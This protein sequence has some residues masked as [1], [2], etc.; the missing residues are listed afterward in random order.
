[1]VNGKIATPP[2]APSTASNLKSPWPMPSL[3]VISLNIQ[4]TD[5]R[6]A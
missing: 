3:P 1:M 2:H 5:H 6:L 4:N